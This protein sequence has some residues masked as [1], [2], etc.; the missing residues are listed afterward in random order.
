MIFQGTLKSSFEIEG[1]GLHGG[2][3]SCVCV[4]PAP[5]DTGIRFVPLGDSSDSSGV[6]AHF[7][8]LH[9]TNNAIT[10]GSDDFIIRTIEHFMAA[11]YVYNVTNAVVTLRGNEMPILDGSSIEIVRAVEEA[12]VCIQNEFQR[13]VYIPYPIWIEERGCYLIALPGDDFKVT[14]TIDFTEKSE[15][16]GTQTAH[17]TIN[18]AVFKKSIAPA[19]T[20]GLVEEKET[21]RKNHLAL[22]GSLENALHFTRDGLMNDEL[23]FHN[24][25]VRHKILDLIGDLSLI[26]HRMA[27]HFIAYKAGHSL[28]LD[29]VRKIDRVVRRSGGGRRIAQEVVRRKEMQF[30]RFMRKINDS[31]GRG[32]G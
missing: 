10:I 9:S 8:N 12:G 20:F 19:R 32:S 14:Y 2:E 24:E 27:G 1:I 3:K 4:E 26:G 18:P 6:Q 28:H 7:S 29:F 21:L 25:C 11:F 31:A 22:G 5:P 30:R 13:V 16:I 15:A 17:Y 23:R